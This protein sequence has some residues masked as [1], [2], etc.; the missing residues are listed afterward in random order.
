MCTNRWVPQCHNVGLFKTKKHAR[1]ISNPKTSVERVN[2]II[3]RQFMG[4]SDISDDNGSLKSS[5]QL[6]Y[7]GRCHLDLD[8][9]FSGHTQ[10]P[11][12]KIFKK[13]LGLFGMSLCTA[14]FEY[15]HIYIYT[16]TYSISRFCSLGQLEGQS[17][18]FISIGLCQTQTS[19]FNINPKKSKALQTFAFLHLCVTLCYLLNCS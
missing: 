18:I 12:P 4:G 15:D 16:Y 5:G 11:E 3:V 7:R 6:K 19:F 2:S 10:W 17:L 9:P 14:K 1:T 13:H 8:H